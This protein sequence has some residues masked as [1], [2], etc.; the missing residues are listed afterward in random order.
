MKRL[1]LLWAYILCLLLAVGLAAGTIGGVH[2]NIQFKDW[3]SVAM[4]AV[5]GPMGAAFFAALAFR[6]SDHI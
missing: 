6:L 4:W 5:F 1:L 3:F 2:D